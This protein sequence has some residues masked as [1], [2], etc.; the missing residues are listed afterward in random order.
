[1]SDTTGIFTF[2]DVPSLLTQPLFVT[3]IVDV[4]SY[5]IHL[6]SNDRLRTIIGHARAQLDSTG[7]MYL[8]GFIRPTTLERL[9]ME[10][11]AVAHEA[12]ATTR[13]ITPYGDDGTGHDDLPEDHPRRW[14]GTWSNGF[15]GKDRIPAGTVIRTLYDDDNFRDFVAACLGLDELHQ[16]DDPIRGLVVNVMGDDTTQAWHYDANEFVVS[17][18]TRRSPSGGAFEYCPNLREIGD[19]HYDD[20]RAVIGGDRARVR[21]LDLEVGDLQLFRGRYSLHRVTQ[22]MGERHTVLFGFS[23]TPGYIANVETTLLG[24]GRVTQAH[25]D[26]DADARSIDGLAG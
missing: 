2:G 24:Y 20:V 13:N 17:L 16:F 9:T 8:P 4:E 1:L 3:D 26:A 22:T 23:E 18:M 10:T 5:P 7:C 25:I 19:E 14:A 21:V 12:Y 6:A 11:N 15:V